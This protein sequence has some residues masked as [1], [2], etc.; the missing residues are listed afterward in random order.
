M[1]YGVYVDDYV[2]VIWL[3]M[4][5]PPWYREKVVVYLFKN[6]QKL[7]RK[8]VIQMSH[9]CEAHDLPVLGRSERYY[10]LPEWKIW[11]TLS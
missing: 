10:Y 9:L 3:D 5:T 8:V 1:G 11:P 7:I 2:C 4:T 6:K